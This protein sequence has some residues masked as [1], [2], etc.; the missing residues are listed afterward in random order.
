M[1][2]TVVVFPRLKPNQ[3]AWLRCC[4]NEKETNSSGPSLPLTPSTRVD[5]DS[6]LI[7]LDGD[8]YVTRGD[9]QVTLTAILNNF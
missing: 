6:I 1:T 3:L 2:L 5:Q 7:I 8:V 4:V 9:P